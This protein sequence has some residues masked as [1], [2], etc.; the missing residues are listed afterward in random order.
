MKSNSSQI[1]K[2]KKQP[3]RLFFIVGTFIIATLLIIYLPIMSIV[4]LNIQLLSKFKNLYKT[5]ELVSFAREQYNITI[6]IVLTI[7]TGS[8]ITFLIIEQI[9]RKRE[10]Q[11]IR[12]ELYQ[13]TSSLNELRSELTGSVSDQNLLGKAFLLIKQYDQFPLRVRKNYA[14]E[15]LRSIVSS[16]MKSQ[17]VSYI[18]TPGQMVNYDPSIHET[19]EDVEE[20]HAVWIVIPGWKDISE[21][22]LKPALTS[23]NPPVWT[24]T[25]TR[26][27]K[28]KK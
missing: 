12:F 5:L 1:P 16:I 14:I 24:K 7:I 15:I 6:I 20:G 23:S 9:I 8:L 27:K 11:S 17:K 10:I 25:S 19:Y 13:L 22:T 2:E 28:G 3:K 26:R 4:A 18:G 21:H